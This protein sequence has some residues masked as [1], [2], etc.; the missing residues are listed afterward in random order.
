[1]IM[2]IIAGGFVAGGLTS[3]VAN[4]WRT[5]INESLDAGKLISIRT[6]V[7]CVVFAAYV[8]ALQ[9]NVDPT[10]FYSFALFG[11]ML[12]LLCLL[13]YD[14]MTLPDNITQ[15][16]LW[17]GLLLSC[18]KYSMLSPVDAIWGATI[19]YMSLWSLNMFCVFVF[20][21]Q[22]MGHGDFKLFAAI[23]AWLGVQSLIATMAV[24]V[25][26]GFIT[27]LYFFTS[28]KHKNGAF[29]FGIGLASG[30]VVYVLCGDI[31]DMFLS[32]L[33]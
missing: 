33:S 24:A 23:G 22:G 28:K 10:N 4:Q 9:I 5:V 16:L 7:S 30:A 12:W 31:V 8:T 25:I 14:T 32:L 15:P 26:V 21:K 19:G 2:S 20:K 29:P 1:M 27:A 3:I 18:T 11:L 13:D 6:V 17:V